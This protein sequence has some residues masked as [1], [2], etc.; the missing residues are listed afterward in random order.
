MDKYQ[1]SEENSAREA[2]S[3]LVD[4]ALLDDL[5]AAGHRL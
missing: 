1:F 3:D 5:S 2:F 4:A